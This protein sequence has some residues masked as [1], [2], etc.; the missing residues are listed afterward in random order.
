MRYHWGYV[1]DEVKVSDT[2][3]LVS[4]FLIPIKTCCLTT[5]NFL[6]LCLQKPRS[7]RCI[8]C[9]SIVAAK[10]SS[11]VEVSSQSTLRRRILVRN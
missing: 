10:E 2:L 4:F 6:L 1:A 11:L 9:S 8:Y 5:C 7:V 3:F